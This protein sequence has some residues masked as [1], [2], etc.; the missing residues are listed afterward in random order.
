MGYRGKSGHSV[1]DS[2]SLGLKPWQGLPVE[3]PTAMCQPAVQP[4]TATL[5]PHKR[6]QEPASAGKHL[7][8][9][10]FFYWAH[11]MAT[12]AARRAEQAGRHRGPTGT[13]F[14]DPPKGKLQFQRVGKVSWLVNWKSEDLSSSL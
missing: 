13:K 11:S 4:L 6:E 12:R 8:T 2:W 10:I 3:T 9:V 5:P 1:L 7:S 14:Q